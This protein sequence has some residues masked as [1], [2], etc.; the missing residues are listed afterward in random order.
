M[1]ARVAVYGRITA[2]RASVLRG[3]LFACMELADVGCDG[4]RG[5]ERAHPDGILR[6]GIL[7]GI[8]RPEGISGRRRR[9]R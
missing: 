3:V 7:E 5:K 9:R 6:D 8:T 1:R 2:G 4:A